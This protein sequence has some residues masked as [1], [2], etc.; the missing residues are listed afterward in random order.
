MGYLIDI[1]DDLNGVEIIPAVTDQPPQHL[2]KQ[3]PYLIVPWFEIRDLVFRTLT[4]G[5]NAFTGNSPF[6][7]LD[8]AAKVAIELAFRERP[9][10]PLDQFF[11]SSPI[12]AASSSAF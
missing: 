10:G 11:S 12:S 1:K 8:L 5:L 9:P 6:V 4:D 7:F 3:A 2:L